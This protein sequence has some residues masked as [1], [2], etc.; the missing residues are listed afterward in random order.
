MIQSLWISS[1][2]SLG[3]VVLVVV[4]NMS[5]LRRQKPVQKGSSKKVKSAPRNK[6][7][8]ILSFPFSH[9]LPK[10]FLNQCPWRSE[11]RRRRED[12]QFSSILW[13]WRKRGGGGTRKST[14]NPSPTSP[15]SPWPQG[16]SAA[17]SL[18]W[19]CQYR[20]M[21]AR[22]FSF[23]T[24]VSRFLLSG[25]LNILFESDPPQFVNFLKNW[26]CG[27]VAFV[28]VFSFS[29]TKNFLEIRKFLRNSLLIRKKEGRPTYVHFRTHATYARFREKNNKPTPPPRNN[30]GKLVRKDPPQ[31]S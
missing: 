6:S 17:A 30:T 23:S 28:G 25:F 24:S 16:F 8:R 2:L 29:R 20:R 14:E 27:V 15:P 7:F 21:R 4:V 19:L 26:F 1:H 11:E 18:P 31:N 22:T 9:C 12:R 10:R 13:I 5:A 3:V